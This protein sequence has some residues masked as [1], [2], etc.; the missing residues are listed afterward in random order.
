MKI[1]VNIVAHQKLYV[2]KNLNIENMPSE[3]DYVKLYN[4]FVGI[5]TGCSIS[6]ITGYQSAIRR[7]LTT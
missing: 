7:F 5:N 6:F 3:S 1:N 4:C 2:K